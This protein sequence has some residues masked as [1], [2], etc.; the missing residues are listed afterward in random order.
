MKNN[1]SENIN[2]LKVL[3]N[4]SE[5]TDAKKLDLEA[6]TFYETIVPDSTDVIEVAN[7]W[8]GGGYVWGG[9]SGLGI[10]LMWTNPETGQEEVLKDKQ[11]KGTYC[12][13]YALQVGYIVAKNRGLLTNK[14]KEQLLTFIKEW[15]QSSPKTCVTASVNL[16][17]G[18]EIEFD[19]AQE[20]DFCQ[21]WRTDDSGHNVVF[22]NFIYKNDIEK[23]ENV[24]LD[25]KIVV[26]STLFLFKELKIKDTH[27][28]KIIKSISKK[29]RV[30]KRFRIYAYLVIKSINKDTIAIYTLFNNNVN[31]YKDNNEINSTVHKIEGV[32]V[33]DNVYYFVSF[34]SNIGGTNLYRNKNSK[35]FFYNTFEYIDSTNSILKLP[36]YLFL[37]NDKSAI[38]NIPE[39]N[40]FEI[41][42]YVDKKYYKKS[43]DI[44]RLEYKPIIR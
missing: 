6:I 31:F 43:T 28:N 18:V 9:G 14:T 30:Q 1:L 4:I 33:D 8:E 5:T 25:E 24:L 3:M 13:G 20:G 26:D 12:S 17:I 27:F 40:Y 10:P 36:S 16:G 38:F 35:Q 2:R 39:Y 11:N 7:S 37:N 23:F 15:Y 22:K 44:N 42:Y 29:Y 34:V 21:L 41:Y 32:Y 19:N